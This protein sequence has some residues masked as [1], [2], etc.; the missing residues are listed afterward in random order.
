MK[1]ILIII[2]LPIYIFAISLSHK[3]ITKMVESIKVE[4]AGLG[5]NVLE[6]TPNPFAI[7]KKVVKEKPKKEKIEVKKVKVIKQPEEI[8][9]LTA[10]LNNRAFINGKWYK[11]GSK[12]GTYTIK[13]MGE[14]S[15]ILK[16][17]RG[18]KRLKIKEREK[19]FKMFKGN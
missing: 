16:N 5:L 10:I 11:V 6:N 17:I 14:R 19:K 3:E 2:L 13:A 15:V 8:Y 12:I 1:K 4:R 7:E 18:E 9:E